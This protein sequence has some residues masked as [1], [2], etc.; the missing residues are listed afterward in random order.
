[1]LREGGPRPKRDK[2]ENWLLVWGVKYKRIN[3]GRDLAHFIELVSMVDAT[4]A[5]LNGFC[6]CGS[7][8]LVVVFFYLD[9]LRLEV[10]S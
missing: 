3:A 4:G 9:V 6:G 8:D 1:M 2:L 7:F 5:R 10:K